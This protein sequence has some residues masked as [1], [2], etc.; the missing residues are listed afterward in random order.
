VSLEEALEDWEL[1]HLKKRTR[2]FG[3]EDTRK[4]IE[5][6]LQDKSSDLEKPL[7]RLS[8]IPGFQ[9]TCQ[10]PKCEVCQRTENFFDNSP[11]ERPW[12]VN[13]ELWRWQKECKDIWLSNGGRGIVKV[14]TGAGKTVLAL[15]LISHMRQE[16]YSDGGLKSVI[17][18][19]NTALLDQWYEEVQDV[20][21]LGEEDIGVFYGEEKNDIQDKDLMIYVLNSARN[22]LQDHLTDIEDDV[23][24]VAD[25]CHR[26]ASEKS[27]ELFESTFDYTV[28]LSAT[29]E[30]EADYGF[31]EVLEPNLG[32]TIYDYSYSDA[33]EDGII[34]PFHLK[35]IEVPLQGKEEEKYEELTE[36]LNDLFKIIVNKYP[37]LKNA[38]GSDF[39]KTLGKLQNEYDDEKLESYTVL[40]NLRKEII[41]ESNS[42]K[43]ALR[44]IINNEISK[45]SRTLIFHERKESADEIYD[46]LLDQDYEAG[47]Y[48]T[49]VS[50]SD[51]REALEDYR[52]GELNMLVTCKALDEG[53]DVPDT[54]VGIIVAAT[55][56]VRQRIQ[57]IGRILRRS[58]GKDYAQIYTIYIKDKEEAIFDKSQIKDLEKT[59]DEVTVQKLNF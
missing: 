31:E 11:E 32:E 53:L 22:E 15:S 2:D 20:L 1:R 29:P 27:T 34:P 48:H 5:T 59:A 46:F 54:D 4:E 55:S 3:L 44:Y 41:H 49:D 7:K 36:Q 51:R 33:R 50:A 38:E 45:D 40:A 28:G 14:V 9:K 13:L 39:L 56:S 26:F 17:V 18:V 6:F 30:R 12:K 35:R 47:I 57:R 16:N 19:P 25:E 58:P 10:K 8:R 23:F 21:N 42:K 43:S 52:E 37:K 24:L